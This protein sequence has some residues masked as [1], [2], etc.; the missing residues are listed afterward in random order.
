MRATG[1]TSAERRRPITWRLRWGE[2]TQWG[3]LCLLPTLLYL[4][5]F[6]IFPVVFSLYLSFTSW[7]MVSAEKPWVGFDNYHQLL[8][9]RDFQ[10]SLANTAYFSV[11]YVLLVMLA[12]L[13]LALL[14]NIRLP[15]VTFFRAIF[16]TPAVVSVIAVSVVWVWLYEPTYGL[17]NAALEAV[18]LPPSQWLSDPAWAMPGIILMMVWKNAGYFMVIYLAGLK[19]IPVTLYEA[20]AIDG[21]NR[22]KNFRYITLPLLMP[23]TFFIMVMATINSFQVFGPIYVMTAGGPVK[24]TLVIAYYLYQQA[25]SFFRM[26]YA[27]AIAYILFAIL[28]VLALV[29]MRWFGKEVTY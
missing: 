7:D 27:S 25:F 24:A 29:Q 2:Q 17:L 3:I 6:V 20:A 23:V 4:L 16:Y 21:A 12:S 9:D 14:L 8:T 13:G 26:G 15:G 1:L 5:V 18:G 22:W 11:G 10:R 19:S 28:F